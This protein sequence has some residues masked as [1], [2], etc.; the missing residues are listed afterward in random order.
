M[1][2]CI[3]IGNTNIVL[4]LVKD[5][6]IMET[7]RFVTNPNLT[8][9]DYY[10]KIKLTCENKLDAN[11][12]GIIIS[13]VVPALDVV[14]CELA[15]KYYHIEPIFV[16]PGIKSGL[17]LKIENPKSLGAD[18][19]CDMVGAVSK[20]KSPCIIVD[21]GTATKFLI[22]NEAKEFIGA[23]IAPGIK[24]ALRSLVSS[25]ALLSE[26][27]LV[28]PSSVIGLNTTTCIQSGVV[29]GYAS[30]ID[31]MITKIKNELNLIDL[32]VILTGGLAKVISKALTTSY[33]YDPNILLEGLIIL[34]YKNT[35]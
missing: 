18:L 14:F 32:N 26:T 4:G 34:Y 21:L 25:A 5:K 8:S 29:Y 20:Y 6:K 7:Y 17:K 13:N 27:P 12:E 10:H 19:L 23:S 22:V 30:L 31:G 16:G 2:L 35:K 15:I 33:N 3:D 1:L 11:I 24:G 9:D 28:M